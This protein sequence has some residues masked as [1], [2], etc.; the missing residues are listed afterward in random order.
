LR[1]RETLDALAPALGTPVD[2]AMLEDLY[3][4]PGDYGGVIAANADR[5]KRMLVIGHNP[6]VQE[7]AIALMAAGDPRL[8]GMIHDKFPTSAVAVIELIGDWRDIRPLAGKLVA[9]L[10]P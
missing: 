9:F 3:D 5:A 4:P 10:M 7:T 8:R 1:T 6:A 2:T